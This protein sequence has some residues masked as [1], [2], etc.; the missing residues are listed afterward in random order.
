MD[1]LATSHGPLEGNIIFNISHH[2]LDTQRL[3]ADLFDDISKT[4]EMIS[5]ILKRYVPTVFLE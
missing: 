5:E 4:T 1:G 2:G 3:S